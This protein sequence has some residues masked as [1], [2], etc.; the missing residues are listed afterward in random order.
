MSCQS[1]INTLDT[2][3]VNVNLPRRSVSVSFSSSFLS[4]SLALPL[5]RPLSLFPLSISLSLSSPLLF[6]LSLSPAQL[7]YSSSAWN[8][9]GWDPLKF[10]DTPSIVHVA[11]AAHKNAEAWGH[12]S[13]AAGFKNILTSMSILAKLK[14][15]I[16]MLL[17]WKYVRT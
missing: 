17:V 6:P 2:H 14:R 5:H 4:F 3:S 12:S 11:C 8:R 9:R 10:I 15:N 16:L 13:N 7:R 1:L